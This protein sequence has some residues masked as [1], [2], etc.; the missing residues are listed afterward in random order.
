MSTDLQLVAT[1]DA[2]KMGSLATANR[3]VGD[4]PIQNL[5]FAVFSNQRGGARR[6]GDTFR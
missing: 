1:R 6:A 4:F 3:P 2:S 5:P